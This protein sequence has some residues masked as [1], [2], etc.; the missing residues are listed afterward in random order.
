M[1]ARC[2][3]EIPQKFSSKIDGDDRFTLSASKEKLSHE[4]P[5]AVERFGDEDVELA[6]VDGSKEGELTLRFEKLLPLMSSKTHVL[7][8]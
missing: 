8:S 2:F 6:V 7:I 1:C 4:L 3:I 5:R